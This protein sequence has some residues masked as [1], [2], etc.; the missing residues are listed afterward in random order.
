[1]WQAGI[2]DGR[3][4]VFEATESDA[5]ESL[6]PRLNNLR[7]MAATSGG[8]LVVEHAT[9]HIK[10]AFDCWGMTEAT[11]RLMHRVKEQL[12]PQNAFSPGRFAQVDRLSR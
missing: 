5:G 8:A 7:Q 3:L 10:R 11:N 1:M 6:L 4:R 12:D 2:G 9:P